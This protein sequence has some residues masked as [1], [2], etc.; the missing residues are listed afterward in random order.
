MNNPFLFDKIWNNWK[1]KKNRAGAEK[2]I[3]W[4]LSKGFISEDELEGAV[5]LYQADASPFQL[6]NQ[7]LDA[8]IR[9]GK[10]KFYLDELRVAGEWHKAKEN[11]TKYKELSIHICEEWNR[12]KRPW[13]QSIA[14]IKDRAKTVENSL[15]QSEFFRDNWKKG[16]KWLREVFKFRRKDNDYLEGLTPSI[17]WFS[18]IEHNVISKILEGEYGYPKKESAFKQVT[19]NLPMEMSQHFEDLLEIAKQGMKYDCLR[20]NVTVVSSDNEQDAS[21]WYVL[22]I[23]GGIALKYKGTIVHKVDLE[24][25]EGGVMT[26]K[27]IHHINAFKEQAAN[28]NAKN[29][30]PNLEKQSQFQNKQNENPPNLPI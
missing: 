24:V 6:E 18:N 9:D 10:Y 21:P 28:Y 4:Q 3:D 5:Q 19:Q 15:R 30:N 23:E 8:W 12:A 2:A 22:Q 14:D 29:Y 25:F 26:Q 16:I 13:W 20:Q 17:T 7:T 11:I 1:C 27:A